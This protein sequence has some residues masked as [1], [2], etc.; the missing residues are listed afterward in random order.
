M[1]S[2]RDKFHCRRE[3]TRAHPFN[4]DTDRGNGSKAAQGW[5]S[6]GPGL[7]RRRGGWSAEDG[8]RPKTNIHAPDTGTIIIGHSQDE[9]PLSISWM[10]DQ[11]GSRRLLL[12]ASAD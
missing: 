9:K 1:V 11:V 12:L 2:F 8:R 5:S 7:F 6:S 10:A 4:L 3:N